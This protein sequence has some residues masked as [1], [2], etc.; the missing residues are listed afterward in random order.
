MQFDTTTRLKHPLSLSVLYFIPYYAAFRQKALG[1][2]PAPAPAMPEAHAAPAW[3]QPAGAGSGMR[4][5]RLDSA[6][7]GRVEAFGPEGMAVVNGSLQDSS[8][9][10]SLR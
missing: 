9:Q 6:S 10:I 8:G 2:S 1:F 3:Y 5:V 7:F 4:S